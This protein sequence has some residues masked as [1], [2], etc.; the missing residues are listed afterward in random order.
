[1]VAKLVAVVVEQHEVCF[2]QDQ[3]APL[4][5]PVNAAAKMAALQGDKKASARDNK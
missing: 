1:M 4:P 3:A 2:L 5:D